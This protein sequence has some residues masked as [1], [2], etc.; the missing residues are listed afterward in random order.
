MRN[1]PGLTAD[2]KRRAVVIQDGLLVSMLIR[3]DDLEALSSGRCLHEDGID[4]DFAAECSTIEGAEGLFL[5]V[6]R[7]VAVGVLAGLAVL[8]VNGDGVRHLLCVRVVAVYPGRGCTCFFR[9]EG[10]YFDCWMMRIMLKAAVVRPGQAG[11]EDLYTFHILLSCRAGELKTCM[12][13]F[14]S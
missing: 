7:D 1:I 14:A 10:E 11:N 9:R 2:H 3:D 5:S 6:G 12:I 4:D 13:T 8:D